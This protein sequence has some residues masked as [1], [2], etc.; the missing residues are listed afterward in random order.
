MSSVIAPRQFQL[1]TTAEFATA[2]VKR[3]TSVCPA[4]LGSVCM[5]T[6]IAWPSGAHAG[7]ATPIAG[8]RM[9]T[10]TLPVDDR[11]LKQSRRSLGVFAD[12]RTKAIT[13]PFGE[14]AG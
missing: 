4:S 5:I 2:E 10:G 3:P 1:P 11:R 8:S 12:A 9:Q 7:R 14:N 6:E 13:R